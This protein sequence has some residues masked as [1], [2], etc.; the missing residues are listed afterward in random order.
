MRK[1]I[2][3]GILP[4]VVIVESKQYRESLITAR[5]AMEFGRLG[6]RGM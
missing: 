3:A 2:I 4:G 6:C 5:L 1:R